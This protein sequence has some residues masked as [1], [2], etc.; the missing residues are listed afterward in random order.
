MIGDSCE[1]TY[2]KTGL[3]LA[4]SFIKDEGNRE[5]YIKSLETL[6]DINMADSSLGFNL[7]LLSK[8]E[9]FIGRQDRAIYWMNECN[10]RV[11]AVCKHLN[12]QNEVFDLK[13][14]LPKNSK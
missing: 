5:N 12:E 7:F 1:V 3:F 4:N 13:D 6:V 14:L 11:P 9:Q 10:D 2:W 8:M